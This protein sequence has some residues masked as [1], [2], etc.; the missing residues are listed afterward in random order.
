M[1]SVKTHEVRSPS[2]AIVSVRGTWKREVRMFLQKNLRKFNL[3]DPSRVPDNT[4][5]TH[6]FRDNMLM[7]PQMFSLDVRDSFLT[8]HKQS[9]LRSFVRPLKKHGGCPQNKVGYSTEG[10]LQL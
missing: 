6:C 3:L 8:S 10:L 7:L 9:S 4:E 2:R 5:V 1:F